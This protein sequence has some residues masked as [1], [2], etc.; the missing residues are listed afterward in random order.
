[1]SLTCR[2][3]IADDHAWVVATIDDAYTQY[4]EAI[5][6]KPAPMLDDYHALIADPRRGFVETHRG[7]DDGYTR[8]Y[9][10]R[11]IG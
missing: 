5:G 8:V 3:A 7:I 11:R 2:P 9:F 6:R 1:M 10:S 4:I